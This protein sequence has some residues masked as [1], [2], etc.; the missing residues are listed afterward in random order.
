MNFFI[1]KKKKHFLGGRGIYTL[2]L[3]CQKVPEHKEG[4]TTALK[5]EGKGFFKIK[6]GRIML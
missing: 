2:F 5:Q 1:K 3:V 6:A 4:R